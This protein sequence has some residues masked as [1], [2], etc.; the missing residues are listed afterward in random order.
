M[1]RGGSIALVSLIAG[2]LGAAALV[3]AFQRIR[4]AGE[5]A[6]ALA[7][8]EGTAPDPRPEVALSLP[9]VASLLASW[10]SVGGCGAG[11][12]SASSSGGGI[13][14]VGRSV[15]GG[16]VDAQMLMVG[17]QAQG[18]QVSAFTARLGGSPLRRVGLALYVPVLYKAGDVS[19]LGAPRT[20]HIAGFGDLGLELSYKFGAIDSHQLSCIASVPTGSADAVRE[21]VVL[22]QHLQLGSG[23]PGLTAQYQQTRDQD[24]GLVLLGATASYGGWENSVGDYRAPS[25]TAYAHVGYLRGGWVPSA[26]LTAFGKPVHD[27][28]RGAD[29]PDGRDPLLMLIPALGMEWSNDRIAILT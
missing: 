13:K 18:N 4:A 1:N 2:A 3:P 12:S 21:G 25:A 10:Q 16:L 22:P 26:G 19:V 14:W 23:V 8:A 27:R 28:E 15:T 20:A 6:L 17:T 9:P 24:W 11:G 7:R 29:R 5:V